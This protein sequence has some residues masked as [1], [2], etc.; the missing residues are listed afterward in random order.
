MFDASKKVSL[1]VVGAMKAG[2]TSM[3]DLLQ[4]SSN[5]SLP[6]I[7]ETNQFTSGVQKKRT[8]REYHSL[9]QG[10][11]PKV[12][13]SPNY[14]KRDTFQGVA[15]RIYE[16]NPQAQIAYLT[17]HPV[18]RLLSEIRHAGYEGVLDSN[19]RY[20]W[21]Q[22]QTSKSFKDRQGF[23]IN[24]APR[25]GDFQRSEPIQ[26]SR[27][28]YQ[29]SAYLEAGFSPNQI[30]AVPLI[31]ESGVIGNNFLNFLS[32]AGIQ[33]SSFVIPISHSGMQRYRY[34]DLLI[35]GK[36]RGGIW[37]PDNWIF[38]FPWTGNIMDALR[39][40]RPLSKLTLSHELDTGLTTYFESDDHNKILTYWGY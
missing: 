30:M 25:L 3:Y 20:H 6:Q 32:R 8:I 39:L 17:R 28:G 38:R 40:R 15:K 26:N 11:G 9:F 22:H 37:S 23:Q 19:T 34:H 4:S 13:I 36:E 18:S 5:A 12:D 14:S 1:F 33:L 10:S 29:I 7:K 16:Y 27:Y 2:T 35:R 21:W 31:D 24:S